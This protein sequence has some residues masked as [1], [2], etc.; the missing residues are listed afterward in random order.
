MTEL[1]PVTLPTAESAY[2]SD[3]AAAMEAKVSGSEVPRA[4]KVIAVIDGFTFMTHPNKLAYC[5]TMAVTAPIMAREPTK[6]PKP[7]IM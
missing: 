4:T 1:D 5:P 7:P 2:F 3:L 6:Q